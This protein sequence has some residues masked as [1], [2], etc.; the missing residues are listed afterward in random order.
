LFPRDG[1]VELEIVGMQ[2]VSSIAGEAWEIFERL[3]G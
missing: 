1:V 2:E 3:A